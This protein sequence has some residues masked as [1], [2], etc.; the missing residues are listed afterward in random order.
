LF[1]VSRGSR[2]QYAT[3]PVVIPHESLKLALAL[4]EANLN[5]P[6]SPVGPW[7]NRQPS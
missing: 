2:E 7:L 1:G 5:P 4:N 6:P 3:P